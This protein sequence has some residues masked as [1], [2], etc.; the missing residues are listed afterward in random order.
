MFKGLLTPPHVVLERDLNLVIF[1]YNKPL[2]AD[3]ALTEVLIFTAHMK[4]K[5]KILTISLSNN[6]T[7]H[8]MMLNS[9]DPGVWML[10]NRYLMN[11]V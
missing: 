4:E 1:L 3:K 5:K 6:P 11:I 8:I 2:T 10:S 9:S 7:I